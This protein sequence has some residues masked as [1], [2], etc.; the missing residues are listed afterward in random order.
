MKKRKGI[1]VALALA[2]VTTGAILHKSTDFNEIS[3]YANEYAQ[4]CLT[5][6]ETVKEQESLQIHAKSA[7][8]MDFT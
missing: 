5:S 1:G 6:V 4:E 8:L 3:A 2:C 7:Y